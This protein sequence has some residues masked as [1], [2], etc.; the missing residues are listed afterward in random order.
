MILANP[1]LR[2][3][4]AVAFK[5]GIPH[6]HFLGGPPRWSDLDRAKALAHDRLERATCSGCGTRMEEHGPDWKADPQFTVKAE[7]CPGCREIAR[8]QE[9]AEGS[10]KGVRLSLIPLAEYDPDDD[11]LGAG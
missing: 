4:L 6:S 1:P 5:L 10:E 8:G 9:A 3:E 2:E 11:L 7:I